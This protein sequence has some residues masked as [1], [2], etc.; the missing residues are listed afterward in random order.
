MERYRHE[1]TLKF[2]KEGLIL[3]GGQLKICSCHVNSMQDKQEREDIGTS[4][5]VAKFKYWTPTLT[6]QTLTRTASAIVRFS[7]LC[8]NLK[9]KYT[10][11][12]FCVPD[13]C[14]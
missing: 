13:V 11:P 9:P 12:Q 4:E 5:I 8:A 14:L 2:R 7:W 10:E 3:G 1:K 6:N